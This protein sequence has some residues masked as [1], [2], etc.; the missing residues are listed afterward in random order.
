MQTR[1]YSRDSPVQDQLQNQH[2]LKMSQSHGH[3]N[4]KVHLQSQPPV[5]ANP[6]LLPRE[7][8]LVPSLEVFRARMDGALNKLA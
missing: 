4:P 3:T 6:L 8:V 2:L 5:Q 7:S 1:T